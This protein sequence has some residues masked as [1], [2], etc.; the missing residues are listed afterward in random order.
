MLL[1]IFVFIVIILKLKKTKSFFFEAKRIKMYIINK[2]TWIDNNNDNNFYL[3][4]LSVKLFF[5]TRLY[6]FIFY[7]PSSTINLNFVGLEF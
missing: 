6:L 5:I 3:K 2:Y 1:F 4:F 7:N